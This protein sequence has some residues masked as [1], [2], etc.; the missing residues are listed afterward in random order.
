MGRPWIKDGKI[1]TS[2]VH[3]LFDKVRFGEDAISFEQWLMIFIDRINEA[4]DAK[5]AAQK[6]VKEYEEKINADSRVKE[7]KAKYDEATKALYRGFGISQ[8]ESEAITE[9]KNQHDKNQHGLFTDSM[10]LK[11]AGVSGGRYH[12]EFYP[13]SIGTSGMCVCNTCKMKAFREAKGDLELYREL[14]K[15]YDAKFEFQDLG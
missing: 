3:K 13:T 7:I 11:A 10:K 8:G 4:E 2:A 6:K 9:W 12:Y 14:L 1:D 15:K 5:K